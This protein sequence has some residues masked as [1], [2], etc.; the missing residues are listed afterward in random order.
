MNKE[1]VAIFEYLEREKGIKRDVVIH[2]IE[3]ALYTA[4]RKSVEGSPDIHVSIDA[5]TG[6]IEIVCKKEVVEKISFP[7]E[8]I[9]LDIAKELYP[10][11]EIGDFVDI[12]IAPERFGRIAAQAARQLMT[13]K[14]RVAERDVI[15]Q[16][17]RHRIHD[18]VSGT[19]KRFVRAKGLLVDLGKVEALLPLENYPKTEHYNIGDRVTALLLEVRDTENGGAEVILT[20]SH[21]EFV[22]ELFKQ[23][24]PELNDGTIVIEKIVRDA[25]YRTK[26]A[27]SSNDPRVDPVGSCV[28]VRGTRV[29]N[30]IHE[31]NNEKID[32]FPNSNDS[33][34]L[35]QNSLDP[36]EIK[37]LG[38]DEEESSIFF[39]VNDDDYSKVIGK[40]GANLR[41]N[42]ALLGYDLHVKKLNEYNQEMHIQEKEDI[43]TF[44]TMEDPTLD[45]E[46]DF[47]D[48]NPLIRDSLVSSG[49]TTM[50][51]ILTTPKEELCETAGLSS[52]AYEKLIQDLK[53]TRA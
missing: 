3:E 38:I 24:V 15:M 33:V 41:L 17:F 23:E 14:L 42:E 46:L 7:G 51:K 29:K 34:E 32:L 10:E 8:E 26:I 48:L 18:I 52:E 22:Q 31:L 21:P 49:Y 13:Q 2:A 30:I 25:G 44:G 19:V 6:E 27:V 20:R 9:T 50:R 16:E 1:L 5:K 53:K 11:S 40:R 12:S 35:L 36:I 47:K 37:K 39:V 28:G 43:E 4:A 45:E